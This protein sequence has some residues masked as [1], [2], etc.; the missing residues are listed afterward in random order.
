LTTHPHTIIQYISD[1]GESGGGEEGDVKS[2]Q[3]Y[4][5]S[6][7]DETEGERGRERGGER[8]WERERER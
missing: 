4:P 6:L 2:N 3:E 8:E 5:S 7:I 1:G